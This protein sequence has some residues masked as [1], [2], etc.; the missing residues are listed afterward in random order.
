MALLTPVSG[1]RRVLKVLS[2]L[3]FVLA[4]GCREHSN[5]P[6]ETPVANRV[7]QGIAGDADAILRAV[8][9][10]YRDAPSYSDRGRVRLYYRHRG[11]IFQDDAPLQ[12]LAEYPGRLR[13]EA[14]HAVVVC[15]GK[16]LT[17]KIRDE[18]SGDI[19]GQILVRE[20]QDG[21]VTLEQLYHDAVL[22]DAMTSGLA[23]QPMQLELLLGEN[24]LKSILTDNVTRRL[25]ESDKFDGHSCHRVEATTEEGAFV[26]WIDQT[27]LLL[28]RLDY[29]ANSILPA[30]AA[31][32]EVRDLRLTAEFLD[33]RFKP[34]PDAAAFSFAM[35]AERKEVRALVLPPQPLP[36]QLFGQRP[37]PFEF[38]NMAGDRL[39]Q[40]D[41]DGRATVLLW[42]NSHPACQTTMEQLSAVYAKHPRDAAAIYAV[43]TEPADVSNRQIQ[44][45]LE[46]WEVEL[47]VLR[48]FQADG[49]DVFAIPWAPALLVLDK[50]GVVQVFEVGA[51]VDLS[52]ELP[53][54][55]ERLQ[56]G[57]DLAAEVL[58]GH[59]R[60]EAEY[61]RLLQTAQ[62]EGDAAVI[63]LA[64]AKI[65]P[66]SE[67]Q[68]AKL[69]RLWAVDS[70][71]APGNIKL[72]GRSGQPTLLVIDDG[73][74]VVEVTLEGQ[75]VARH[76]LDLDEDRVSALRIAG[77][78]GEE[79]Y[80]AS[81]IQG[82]FVY[83]FDAG[84]QRILRYPSSE[85]RHPGIFDFQLA[86]LSS[87]ESFDVLIGFAGEIGVQSVSPD[88][89]RAWSNRGMANVLSLVVTSGETGQQRLLV[90]GER[91][92]VLPL[93]EAGRSQPALR[94]DGRNIFHLFAG[95]A[96]DAAS[97]YCALTYSEAGNL[98][99]LGLDGEFREVWSY[100]L[101]AGTFRN[102]VELVTSGSLQEQPHWCL[103]A[104][105]GTIH[106][107]RADGQS[108][109]HFA[110]GDEIT[111]LALAQDVLVV[112]TRRQLVAWRIENP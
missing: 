26:F 25:L 96:P 95:P 60:Q 21:E 101:P 50:E 87:D 6:T 47:P 102:P 81:S 71:R 31:T 24:P 92:D 62:G 3:A 52:R 48:D 112:A 89:K 20:I 106:W 55:L 30:L 35:P 19:D 23:R 10:A 29:P 97:V 91:G 54:I 74:A 9:K 53:V 65:K 73:R 13:V 34:K 64:L 103:A 76:D 42:F 105:D 88:G 41:F 99:A 109:D 46:E 17:A 15:D 108:A 12:V 83:L 98:V 36:S 67:P 57:D 27:E 8:A 33:A 82:R 111:G 61:E 5:S 18:F 59:A 22:R 7:Q 93:D 78:D 69:K 77:R 16:N 28:R 43:S 72:R 44:S 2:L 45:Q 49:R 39:G 38:Q 4:V 63:D 66:R 58:A 110:Y 84:W 85:Q 70:L 86:E 1:R 40:S 79:R 37:E 11:D 56:S 51:N 90:T 104:P 94:V 32:E 75:I 68:Q 14:Y 80:L 100:P 107:I